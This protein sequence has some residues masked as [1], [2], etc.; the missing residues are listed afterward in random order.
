MCRPLV[1]AC[2]GRHTPEVY[3][4]DIASVDGSSPAVRTAPLC[5]ALCSDG[6][7]DN[8]KFEDVAKYLLDG[9]HYEA[10]VA[11]DSAQV[12]LLAVGRPSPACPA[13]PL[14]APPL[15]CLPRPSP[16][17]PAPA[18][19]APPLPAPPLP[20]LPLPC[21][22]RPCLPRPSTAHLPPSHHGCPF[23]AP[24]PLPQAAANA[25]MA[26]NLVRAQRNFGSSADNMT[27][28]VLYL[29]PAAPAA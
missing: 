8:W 16:A 9:A 23:L 13:P 29:P 22:P 11:A 6:V 18:C 5:I 14:P 24:L 1:C 28:V 3:F 20:C 17:C 12:R 25:L 21:L 7:W 19:P 26:E 2:E 27:A 15:P 10:S 4:L